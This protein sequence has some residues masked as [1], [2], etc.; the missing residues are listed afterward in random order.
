MTEYPRLKNMFDH[1]DFK[2]AG[3]LYVARTKGWDDTCPDNYW[4]C[5]GGLAGRPHTGPLLSAAEAETV[6]QKVSQ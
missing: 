5:Q 4:V 1:P 3:K 6:I 2:I